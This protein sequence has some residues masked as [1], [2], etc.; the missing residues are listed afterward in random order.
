MKTCLFLT[1]LL[2]AAAL[3]ARADLE[4]LHSFTAETKLKGGFTTLEGQHYCVAEKG[5]EHGYGF[6]GQFDP[7]EASLSPLYSFTTDA[8]PKGGLVPCGNA[9][10]LQGEKGALAGGFGWI[11]RFRPA[12]KEFTELA[13]FPDDVK[14]KSGLIAVG[15]ALWLA[16]EKGGSG[17]GSIERFDP[18]TGVVSPVASLTFELGIKIESFVLHPDR[19][20]FYAGAREGGDVGELAGKGAGTLL[21]VDPA[22]GAIT[23]LAVFKAAEHGAKLRGLTV[24]AGELWFVMEEGGDLSLNGGKGAGTICSYTIATGTLVRR[25]RFDG[26]A[27]GLKPK[28]LVSAGG[29]LYFATEAG[30]AAG[31]GVFGRIVP[32][33][34]PEPLAEFSAELGAKPDHYLSV[35]GSRILFATELGA[36]GYLGGILG[37]TLPVKPMN[38]PV[39]RVSR[40]DGGRV[41]VTWPVAV[42]PTPELQ[43]A[44]A[45]TGSSW[46]NVPK[47]PA[48]DGEEFAVEVEPAEPVSFWRLRASGE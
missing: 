48:L 27:T 44:S 43:H 22:T 21:Q 25:H 30:G 39:L 20:I 2:S 8:K 12:T 3:T 6:I 19:T 10:Y 24:H 32:G 18:M 45:L 16:T 38:A 34:S 17:F 42:S 31:F 46:V 28:G 40:L 4:L 33:R 7:V 41:R 26:A 29:D 9:V 5:G 14:P 35:S 37:W 23:R 1:A 11:G 13:S 47:P 15:D 36:G